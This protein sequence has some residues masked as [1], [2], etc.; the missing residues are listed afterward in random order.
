VNNIRTADKWILGALAAC[1]VVAIIGL[2]SV[3]VTEK[4]PADNQRYPPAQ[5]EESPSQGTQTS[6]GLQTAAGTPYTERSCNSPQN[7]W[8]S[9]IEGHS[10]SLQALFDGILIVVGL[11]QF[12]VYRL[13][14]AAAHRPKLRVR[15]FYI[16]MKEADAKTGAFTGQFYVVNIGDSPC[17]V[18]NSH[19]V[20]YWYN[21]ELPM[22]RPFEGKTPND[23]FPL[24]TLEAGDSVPA[25]FGPK[26]IVQGFE[27]LTDPIGENISI[28]GFIDYVDGTGIRRR[29]AFCRTYDDTRKRFT[30]SD[31]EDYE[32]E[33]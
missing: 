28:L 25:P 3:P 6:S 19:I 26:Q 23:Q 32:H 20:A 31:N 22:K 5:S 18:I 13:T 16:D 29:T 14:F 8:L 10:G 17:K 21:G 4:C 1:L 12:N 11:L 15:N 24:I 27:P 7:D 2:T 33:E 9:W 30:R